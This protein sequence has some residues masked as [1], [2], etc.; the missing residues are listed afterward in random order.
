MTTLKIPF[1]GEP[2]ALEVPDRNLAEVLSPKPSR[3]VPDLD[4]AIE[5]ALDA[6]IAQ[7]PLEVWVKPRDR[8]LIVSDDATRLTPVHR[9]LPAL[10]RRLHAAG[11]PDAHIG[12][13]MA[14]GTHRYM[15]ET[16]LRVKVGDAV[17]ERI[18]VFNHEWRDPQALVDLGTSSQG[19]PLLVNRAVVE[20]DVVIGLGAIV[21]H[22]IPG[23]SGS[24]KIIQPGVC[25]DRTTAET[26]LLSCESGGDSY[27][28]I[29]DNPVRRDM[30]DMADR[31]GLRTIFNAVN[32]AG[33]VVGLFYGAMRPA[34]KAGVKLARELYG[35][36]YHET[37]DIV[38]ANSH[39]CDLDFWQSHKSLYPGQRMVKPGGT[40]IVCT[41]APEGVSPVHTELLEFTAW[42]S[43]A[44]KTAYR[45][46]HLTNGVACALAIAWAMVR[47]QAS[48]INYSPGITPEEKAALGHTHAPTLDWAVEEALRRQ[49]PNARLTVLTHAPELLPIGPVGG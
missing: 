7:P 5:A 38:L 19:T 18:R 22:H 34:F 41:P 44:I 48:V 29:E 4:A 39:P 11:V 33:D 26:H 40:I 37:P 10:L 30:D 1:G 36:P 17:F 27:L 21:P 14:L 15:T 25:G 42:P 45:D 12:C 13:I 2:H 32:D 47:E 9:M 8:V 6:P 3:A 46:G 20:A 23:F 49:G 43:Q 24:S 28:G 35:V 31:V 16:E